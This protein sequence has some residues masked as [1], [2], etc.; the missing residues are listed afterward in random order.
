MATSTITQPGILEKT[1]TITTDSNGFGNLV[2]SASIISVRPTSNGICMDYYYPIN[3]A[4]YG[5]FIDSNGTKIV[6][7]TFDAKVCYIPY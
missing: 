5:K 2:S 3:N 1:I 6:S 4:N 7:Q